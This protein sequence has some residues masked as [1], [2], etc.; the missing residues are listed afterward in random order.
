MCSP[1]VKLEKYI[2]IWNRNAW[3]WL[4]TMCCH[5]HDFYV[6]TCPPTINS[7]GPLSMWHMTKIDES[8]FIQG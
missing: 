2:F 5:K 4:D 1:F 6:Y 8:N 7:S 3:I